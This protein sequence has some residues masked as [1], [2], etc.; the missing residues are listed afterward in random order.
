[1]YLVGGVLVLRRAKCVL[2]AAKKALEEEP[3]RAGAE[4]EALIAQSS[5]RAEGR[6]L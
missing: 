5:Q 6:E 1:M 3:A 2:L 4:R